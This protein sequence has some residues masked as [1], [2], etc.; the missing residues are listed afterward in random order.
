MI[1]WAVSH[2]VFI[3]Q[4]FNIWSVVCPRH[5]LELWMS[6]YTN[7]VVGFV[8]CGLCQGGYF[9]VCTI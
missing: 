5:V 3:D 2:K 8:V 4:K 9:W 6:T 1:L 7:P